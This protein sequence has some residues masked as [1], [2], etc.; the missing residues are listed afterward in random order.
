MHARCYHRCGTLS[1][2]ILIWGRP[3]RT[4]A[5]MTE[6][7][8]WLTTMVEDSYA[9]RRAQLTPHSTLTKASPLLRQDL[10]D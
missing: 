2:V 1:I 4:A 5:V 7:L 3:S 10:T 9:T 8:S 6:L